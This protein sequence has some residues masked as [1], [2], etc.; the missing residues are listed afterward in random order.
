MK[1]VLWSQ[2]ISETDS[3][4]FVIDGAYSRYSGSLE[5]DE[6]LRLMNKS[7]F[8]LVKRHKDGEKTSPSFMVKKSKDWLYIEGNFN[9]KDSAER[10]RIYRFT[11]SSTNSKE[12]TQTLENYAHKMEC[13]I[14]KQD[15]IELKNICNRI[16]LFQ[17]FRNNKTLKTCTIVV[18]MALVVCLLWCVL[19]LKKEN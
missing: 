5:Q 13:T 3:E 15:L 14:Y 9:E 11:I 12:I 2:G 18:I 6:A 4:F 16:F 7:P 19:P 1:A 17:N 8:E 10:L